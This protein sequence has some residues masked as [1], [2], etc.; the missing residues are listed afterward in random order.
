MPDAGDAVAVAG[1]GATVQTAAPATA[2]AAPP[3]AV[4]DPS[5][6]ST[7]ADQVAGQLMRLVS[8]G[9]REM[10]MRLHPPELG[11]LTVRVAVNGR[12]VTAW[13]GS[14]QPQVQTAISEGIG[15]L[16]TGLG[17]AGYNSNGAWVGADA[18]EARQQARHHCR[19]RHCPRP[20]GL[21]LSD[22]RRFAAFASGMS[23]YV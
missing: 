17:N 13:F 21:G 1:F 2:S 19:R 9:S 22:G 14:P 12:D 11:D 3:S 15:Q 8:S 4:A 6:T 16:Q 23:I 7:I 18:S 5:A 10:V 20:R